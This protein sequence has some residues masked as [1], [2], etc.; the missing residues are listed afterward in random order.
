MMMETYKC[1]DGCGFGSEKIG[2]SSGEREEKIGDILAPPK[3]HHK[4][5]FVPKPNPL[6][7]KLDT[8]PDPPIFPHST[9]DFQKPIMFV[10]TLGKR[11]RSLVR[12]SRLR[13]RVDRNQM[14]SPIPSLNL[15]P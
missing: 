15:S 2:E 6:L 3:T 7:N 13:S 11:V 10:S 4:N 8:Y 9:N 14:N 1:Q 5:T 12:R